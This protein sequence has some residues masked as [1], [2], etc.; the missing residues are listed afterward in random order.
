[1]KVV[2]NLTSLT[3]PLTGI[4][5][6]TLNLLSRLQHH[7]K[8]S[9]LYGFTATGIVNP[10]AL[11]LLLQ[12]CD[13]SQK[14]H[15]SQT[16]AKWRRR[17]AAL[18]GARRTWHMI[19]N[20]QARRL[21]HSV[22]GCIYW[23][24]N[25]LL[26]PFDG[27]SVATIHDISHIRMPHYHPAD[28]VEEMNRRLP[29]TLQRA[30]RLISVSEFTR[31]EILSC[32]KPTQPIDI[33]SPGVG[34]AFFSVDQAQLQLCRS[35]YNLPAQYILSVATLEPRK[36]L[37]GLVKAYRLLP[38]SLRQAYPLVLAGVRGWHTHSIEETLRPLSE[39]G[40]IRILGYVDQEFIPAL[41]ANAT[42]TAYISHYEGFGMPVAESMAAG[43]PVLTSAVSSMPEVANGHA[44]LTDPADPS[45]CC[46]KIQHILQDEALRIRLAA[47]GKKHAATMTWSA[48]AEHLINSLERAKE[49]SQR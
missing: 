7:P 29:D 31:Q 21:Q 43:T 38:E 18:P 15:P 48:S 4:G 28:R 12:Q 34:E 23:E 16:T 33:V 44:L 37:E 32:L 24:P 14:N 36:N 30:T 39:S 9:E 42:L 11:N 20:L 1:M 27:P 40:Q 6:Y 2:V 46:Q 5:R 25:Y 13:A 10:D 17:L 19:K 45:A 3:P 26:L 35:K 49:H 22:R 41:Y 47:G 8:V